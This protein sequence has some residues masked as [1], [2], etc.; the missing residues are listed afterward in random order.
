VT[1]G[2]T[3][4]TIDAV[5]GPTRCMPSTNVTIGRTVDSSA[6]AT[7]HVQPAPRSSEPPAVPAAK[8]VTVAPVVTSAASRNASTRPEMTSATRM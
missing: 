2:S 5:A 3:V 4:E 1:T 8:N 6:I 7:I